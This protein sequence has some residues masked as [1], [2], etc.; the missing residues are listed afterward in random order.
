[1]LPIGVIQKVRS[2][3]RGEGGSLK[4]ERK[5]T[6]GGG[7]SL[8]VRSLCEKNC[9]IFQTANRGLSDKLGSC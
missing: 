8:S 1:M 7:S 4:S 2:S 3:L 9:L 6:G 5:R